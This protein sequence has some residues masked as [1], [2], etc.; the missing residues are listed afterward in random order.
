M[1]LVISPTKA[2]H[3]EASVAGRLFACGLRH[4]ILRLPRAERAD[5][6]SFLEHIAPEYR[7]RILIAGHYE[8]LSAYDLGGIYLPTAQYDGALP[9]LASWQIV[10]TGVHSVSELRALVSKPRRLDFVLCSPVFDSIS[11]AGYKAS[12]VL[13]TLPQQIGVCPYRLIALGGMTPLGYVTACHWGYDGV[14]VLGDIWSARGEE[15]TRYLA[16]PEPKVLSLAGHDPSGGAGLAADLRVSE[17]LSTRCITIPTMWTAQTEAHFAV[18]APVALD[19]VSKMLDVSLQHRD[20]RVAK[21]GMVDSL[22]TLEWL[23]VQLCRGGVSRIVWDPI[24][25]VSAGNRQVLVPDRSRLLALMARLYLITPNVPECEAWFGGSDQV[26]LQR[27]A[28]ETGCAILLKGGHAAGELSED[29]LYQ[30]HRPAEVC[31]IAR[32]GSPKHGTGC[33]LSAAIAALLAQGV[34]LVEACWVAQRLVSRAMY[35]SSGLL[36]RLGALSASSRVARLREVHTLQYI[37]NTTDPERLTQCCHAYLRGGGRWI[38]LRAKGLSTPER[39]ALARP[40]VALCR[41]YDAV[42][43]VNDDVEAALRSGA[44]GVHLGKDDADVLYARA[45][46]GEDKIIGS[47]CNTAEDLVRAYRLGSDYVGVGPFR[48]TTTKERLAPILGLAGLKSLAAARR[49]LPHPIPMVAIGGITLADAPSVLD[50]GVSGIAVSGAI[51]GA[52]DVEAATASFLDLIAHY[53]HHQDY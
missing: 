21:I 52:A 36:H 19:A 31:R 30:P 20:I 16:Y 27:I 53:S 24:L 43:I 46:L 25:R 10:G 6:E 33:M 17:S 29:H 34:S 49:A 2:G 18:A 28:D 47:T 15:L 40:L 5:Y 42:L 45:V 1:L 35:S 13:R 26:H 14:A 9:S 32:G 11:K 8:L 48:Y 12:E 23:V 44:D 7:R 4:F 51:E 50:T 38:Q 41:R 39:V 3:Y 22:D 37:T